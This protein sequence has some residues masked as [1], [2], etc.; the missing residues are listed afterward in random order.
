[1]VST[2]KTLPRLY[3]DCDLASGQAID[4]SSDQAHYLRHVLRR[5][6]GQS[7]RVFNGR[8]GEWI[9]TLAAVDKKGVAAQAGQLLLP[10]PAPPPERILLFAPIK[11]HR[12]DFLIEKSVE[13]GATVLQ[14]VLTHRT[15]I[16]SLN[17][18]RIRA[19]IAEAAEQCERLDMPSFQPLQALERALTGWPAEIPVLACLERI[20][21]RPLPQR[22]PN[23]ACALLIGP[24]GGFAEEEIRWLMDLP[25]VTPVSLGPR[26][27]RSETAALAAL[28]WLAL[29][30]M[31]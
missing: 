22:K 31:V 23:E 5:E 14:P 27:L 26:I 17:E 25:F 29:A 10:Q 24:E 11:K 28:A 12:L 30:D 21:A 16:R 4:F 1:M 3:V 20:E 6:A 15:D 19:Q 18:D 9:A 7:V 2:D 8:D 13:L